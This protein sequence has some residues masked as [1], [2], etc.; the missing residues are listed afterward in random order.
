M[1]RQHHRLA[2]VA[3]TLLFAVLFMVLTARRGQEGFR[4]MGRAVRSGATSQKKP[5]QGRR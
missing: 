5:Q 4:A 3:A 2:V 1:H